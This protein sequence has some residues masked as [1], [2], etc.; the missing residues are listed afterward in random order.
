[1]LPVVFL[2]AAALRGAAFFLLVPAL[3]RFLLAAF[4]AGIRAPAGSEKNA[5]LY[6]ACPNMEAQKQ[7]F[8]RLVEAFREG[9][10]NG[11]GIA[12]GRRPKSHLQASEPA[13]GASRGR[14]RRACPVPDR[15]HRF[16]R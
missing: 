9:P 2:L 12:C 10:E 3:L 1:L 16:I 13:S 8:C 14:R 7:A 15:R 6:I 4:F 5:E 11:T